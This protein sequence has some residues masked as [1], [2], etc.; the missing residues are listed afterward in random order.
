MMLS[1]DD[2]WRA[3]NAAVRGG[4]AIMS[5][6]NTNFKVYTKEDKSPLTQADL[7]SNELINSSLESTGYPIL[8]EENKLDDYSVRK[9]WQCLWVV[10]PL[11]GTK[12]FIARNGEFTVNI[13]FVVDEVPIFGVIYVPET[14]K[15]FVGDASL[16]KSF[17]LSFLPT[18]YDE[19]REKATVLDFH[20]KNL[21][22][23]I[24]RVFAS[25]SHSNT[26]T[27]DY[28]NGLKASGTAI[29]LLQMGSALKFCRLA[30]GR[31]DVYPRFSPCMEWDVA[32][33]QVIC[34]N[35]GL[36]II[37]SQTEAP[38]SYNKQDLYSCNF[39]VSNS[40]IK[41]N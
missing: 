35:A 5:V 3:I 41:V 23:N 31:A 11:D 4:E 15:I 37:D 12:E 19:V 7:A 1:D 13:A 28:I 10:D 8:S 17:K 18:S 30:E 25:R 16:R 38:P 29:Q 39:V 6:Y 36:K 20:S 34:E 21:S 9:K 2:K 26:L 32:A 40:N 22:S 33:G 24:L 27:L 14:Q